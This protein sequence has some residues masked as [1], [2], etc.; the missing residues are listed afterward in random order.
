MREC[1]YIISKRYGSIFFFFA[2]LK[3]GCVSV[4]NLMNNDERALAQSDEEGF[5]RYSRLKFRVQA[6]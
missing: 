1:A 3:D 4:D 6:H 5:P 2:V